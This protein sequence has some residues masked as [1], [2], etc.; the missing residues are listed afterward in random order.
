MS[1]TT[2]L[3]S[4]SRQGW[5]ISAGGQMPAKPAEMYSESCCL[6]DIETASHYGF[7][8]MHAKK[9]GYMTF[10]E[11]LPSRPGTY[12]LLLASQTEQNLQVGRLGSI[13]LLRGFYVYVGSAFGPGGLNSRVTRHLSAHKKHRWHIDYVRTATKPVAVWY[14]LDLNRQECRW[15]NVISCMAAATVSV[16][17]FGA[18]DCA[19]RSHLF[20]FEERP[21]LPVFRREVHRAVDGHQP[22][23]RCAVA[24]QGDVKRS[25]EVATDFADFPRPRDDH[26]AVARRRLR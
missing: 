24:P 17:G 16:T 19:C 4:S 14:T 5:V 26:S 10:P 2:V 20:Y 21:S 12:A 7:L 8:L 9:Q 15:A 23:R 1:H 11:R 18:S 22:V 6:N 3:H 13:R 25:R